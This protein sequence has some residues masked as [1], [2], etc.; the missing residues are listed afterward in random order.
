VLAEVG[1]DETDPQT[2]VGISIIA[3]RLDQVLERVGVAGTPD[4]VLAADG[5][6]VAA[7]VEI[8]RIKQVA[9]NGAAGRIQFHG[10]LV[11]NE[12]LFYQTLGIEGD[13][14]V[15][16]GR[17]VVGVQ[18]EGLAKPRYRFVELTE[19]LICRGE[20]KR[21][22]RVRPI[23]LKRGLER[24]NGAGGITLLHQGDAEAQVVLACFR[25]IP[26]GAA[27]QISSR[28]RMAPLNEQD[29]K[30]VKSIRMI[31]SLRQDPL[32]GGLSVGEA[33]RL[34]KCEGLIE[35]LIEVRIA[36]RRIVR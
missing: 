9:V 12:R 2:A 21:R 18:L 27:D 30:Q 13:G 33:K 26:D 31:G 14:Q 19:S 5:A 22:L 17:C 28:G 6:G 23:E 1:G 32:I 25:M 10:A 15:G 35:F 11:P 7:G 16:G 8:E 4:V 29:A 36:H 20:M 24:L 34:M 3:M